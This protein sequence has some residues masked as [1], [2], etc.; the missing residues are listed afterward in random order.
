MKK[1]KVTNTKTG[2][3]WID[4]NNPH[5]WTDLCLA[6]M[7]EHK[8]FNLVYC[9]IECLAKGSSWAEVDGIWIVKDTWYMLD[10]C[11]RYEYLPEEYLVEEIE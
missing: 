6:I 7:K 5:S 3:V 8:D 2:K 9:D 11:G 1:L 10:E 4:D